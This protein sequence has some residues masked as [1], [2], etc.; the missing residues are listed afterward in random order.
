MLTFVANSKTGKLEH[1]AG[2]HDDSLISCMLALFAL[3]QP[4]YQ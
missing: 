4:H 1:I 3:S 2:G